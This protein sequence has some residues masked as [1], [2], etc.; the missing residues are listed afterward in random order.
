MVQRSSGSELAR[1][2][3]VFAAILMII[4]G[5]FQAIMGIAA[6]ANGSFFLVAPDYTYEISTTGW[7]WIHLIIGILA[8]V[9]GFFIFTGAVWA[10][11]IGIALAAL[12]AT[13]NFFFMPYYPF[14][15]LLV[16]ALDIFVI[17]AL[18]SARLGPE[19]GPGDMAVGGGSRFPQ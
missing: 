15:S 10:R 14:W 13:A 17:W 6:I 2:G 11:A 5:V 8:V 16:I 12:S 18:V 7:G 3:S 1:G 4:I 19:T 9:A